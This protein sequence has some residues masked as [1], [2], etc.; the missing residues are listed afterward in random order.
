MLEC[1]VVAVNMPRDALFF[2]SFLQFIYCTSGKQ[3]HFTPGKKFNRLRTCALN[4]CSKCFNMYEKQFTEKYC[5]SRTKFNNWSAIATE[6][7]LIFLVCY[8]LSL[9]REGKRKKITL[10][11]LRVSCIY[12]FHPQHIQSSQDML[13]KE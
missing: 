1:M 11:Y 5:I 13:S 7:I 4:L 9:C 6:T 10:K 8:V 3:M 2:F 12:F